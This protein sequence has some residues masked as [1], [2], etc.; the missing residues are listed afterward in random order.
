MSDQPEVEFIDD[1]ARSGKG[2]PL[3]P[4]KKRDGSPRP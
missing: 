3:F 4:L 2:D 1:D